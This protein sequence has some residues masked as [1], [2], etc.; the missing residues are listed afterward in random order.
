MDPKSQYLEQIKGL[1]PDLSYQTAVLNDMGQFNDVLTLDNAWIFRFPRYAEGVRQLEAETRL[2]L[3]LQGR[4]PLPIPC[5]GYFCFD[6]PLPGR[7]CMGYP[8]LPREPLLTL[9]SIP[10]REAG[11]QLAGQLA[12]FLR[13]LHTVP[14]E[15][16]GVELQLA[17]TAESWTC[18]YTEIRKKLFPAMRPGARAQAAAHFEAYLDNPVL[19]TFHPAMRHGDFGGSNL[20]YD[21][22][23]MQVTGVLDFSSCALGDPAADLASIATL[24]EDFFALIAHQYEPDEQRREPLLARARFYRGTFALAEA[25]DGF[26]HHDCGAYERGMEKYR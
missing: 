1:A 12:G 21:P 2:L 13:F 7:V 16:L 8:C 24:G 14:A 19:Q 17:D 18:L 15:S 10:A 22:R 6:P 3:A 23:R 25:L 9:V 26:N 20:L 4:L 5:P 11:E